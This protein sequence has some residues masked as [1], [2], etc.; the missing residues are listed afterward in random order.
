MI[1]LS[2]RARTLLLAVLPLTLSVVLLTWH[3]TRTRVE[4][5]QLELD[6]KGQAIAHQLAP[7][8]EYGV[9]TGNHDVLRGLAQAAASEPDVLGVTI[10]DARGASLAKAGQTRAPG[11]PNTQLR[12]RAPIRQSEIAV[13][14]IPDL[15]GP[16]PAAG[17]PARP[18]TIG[19]VDITV[20]GARTHAR[21][22]R[23]I[24]DSVLISCV[25]LI[26]GILLALRMAR[27]IT[28]PVRRLARSMEAIRNGHL[29]HRLSVQAS[30]ELG[31]LEQGIN[32]MAAALQQSKQ[33]ERRMAED[34]LNEERIRARVTLESIGE[35]VLSTDARGHIT[36]MNPAAEEYT[37]WRSEDAL[38]IPL[39]EVLQIS[40]N[41]AE[42]PT[43]YPIA[44]CLEHGTTL[45]EDHYRYLLRQDGHRVPIR[46][47]AT[48]IR[49]QD[50]SII[51]AVVVLHDV[52]ELQH[53]T[54]R[55]AYLASHDPLT[56]L[57]N[58]SEFETRL[59]QLIL[60]INATDDT[61]QHA[62]CFVDLDHFKVI[63]DTWGHQ[64]GDE[65]LREVARRL[66]QG[67]RQS[68]VVARLGG[69]EFAVI[70][71]NC[72][73][74]SA[75]AITTGMLAALASSR[76]PWHEHQFDVRACAGLT[77]ITSATE[78][79]ESLVQL[80][81]AACYQ[82]KH[83]GRGQ[84]Q[85]LT[86]DHADSERQSKVDKW[87]TR[88]REALSVG[89][90][91]LHQQPI[92]S[93]GA[94]DS[95]HG[96]ELLLR[97]AEPDGALISPALFLPM[98]ERHRLLPEID[99]W[100]LS[101]AAESLAAGGMSHSTNER[102]FINLSTQT[103]VGTDFVHHIHQTL[104]RTGVDASRLCFEVP[105]TALVTHYGEGTRFIA[106]VRALG[107]KAA[108]DDFGSKLTPLAC[109]K[110]L[111]ID[112]VK[113]S[114]S[115][116]AGIPGDGVDEAMVRSISQISHA[117]GVRTIAGYVETEATYRHLADLEIDFAQG[118]WLEAPQPFIPA[119]A[120]P[121]TPKNS[122]VDAS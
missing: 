67:V 114:Q 51:G 110:E 77:P 37:G 104:D 101:Q 5:F 55:I 106:D 117:R 119:D 78:S 43:P 23:A 52:T 40:R 88:L 4:D 11:Q 25:G 8:C 89:G 111:E 73:I 122:Q 24:R 76:I 112:Y 32:T 57:I 27:S 75:T 34:L 96:S 22:M 108:I 82:A 17:T 72:S 41:D 1:S 92:V 113:L 45:R 15:D 102:L 61:L 62:L 49:G 68:D 44:A 13:N 84:V 103:L 7:A 81:D 29:E 74:E 3:Y 98:A 39:E 94:D 21:Q 9:T 56:G 33:Q 26:L 90:F 69:D 86:H 19:W 48:P 53:T 121:D 18:R 14:D 66:Q 85:V 58:R 107:C 63:N 6:Q 80:A 91:A 38:G 2:I 115:L 64:A 118:F 54:T 35:G 20:S 50:D 87:R 70:L 42:D 65:V 31:R 93:I 71:T 16:A 99:R 30:G 97:L 60:S 100:V 47:T 12:F 79:S 36:Y 83:A 28:R 59:E 46:D 95:A 105:E 109:L 120:R 10:T 116:L